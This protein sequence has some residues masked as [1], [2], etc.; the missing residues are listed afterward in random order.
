MNCLAYGFRCGSSG[1]V[2]CGLLEWRHMPLQRLH[3]GMHT[4]SAREDAA[5]A[6]PRTYSAARRRR[7]RPPHISGIASDEAATRN[8]FRPSAVAGHLHNSLCSRTITLP[9][10]PLVQAGAAAD[11]LERAHL[12]E[13]RRRVRLRHSAVAPRPAR[14]AVARHADPGPGNSA[15]LEALHLVREPAVGPEPQRTR[16][17]RAEHKLARAHE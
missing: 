16:L 4:R 11:R 14:L 3:S 5:L 9:T 1:A 2:G 6:A 10:P 7:T 17:A 12:Q 13:R 8:L 15:R